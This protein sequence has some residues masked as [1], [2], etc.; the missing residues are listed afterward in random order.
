MVESAKTC[1]HRSAGI[2]SLCHHLLMRP[3]SSRSAA[4][5]ASRVGHSSMIDLKLEGADM[6]FA[7]SEF[8]DMEFA[9]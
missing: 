7:D 4:A 2:L 6:E 1:A 8:G 3:E 5:M 9:D